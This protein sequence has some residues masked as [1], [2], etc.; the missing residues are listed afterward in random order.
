MF[1]P[2][3]KTAPTVEP[4]T[5]E[6]AQGVLGITDTGSNTLIDACIAGA[7]E[8][9]ED[10]IQRKLITQTWYC[11]LNE[12]PAAGHPDVDPIDTGDFIQLPFGN[13]QSVTKVE[14]RTTDGTWTASPSGVITYQWY[15]GETP[16]VGE[17]AATYT[18]LIGD[19]GS[20]ITCLVTN[21]NDIAAVSASSNVIVIIS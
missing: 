19:L 9:V 16:I 12:W 18:T 20:D 2:V 4:L 13:A 6:I 17:V 1:N 8:F 5:T 14:Y 11:Y 3:L 7:R 10:T 15:N 21:T